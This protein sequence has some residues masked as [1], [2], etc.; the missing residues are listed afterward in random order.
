M[1]ASTNHPSRPHIVLLISDQHN[2]GLM[3]CAG[4]PWV[5]TPHLDQLAAEGC[6]FTQCYCNSPV[7][8]PSRMSMLTGQSPLHN[9][10]LTNR[11]ALASHIP[12]LAHA[13]AA[14]GY[15]TVLC[16]RMHFIG[17]DQRHGFAERLVGEFG[18]TDPAFRELDLG[19]FNHSTG[20]GRDTLRFNG[21]GQGPGMHY[22]REVVDA[23]CERIGTQDPTRPLFMVIGT[24]APHNPYVCDPERFK[25]YQACLPRPDMAEIVNKHARAHPA[26]RDWLAA[27]EML[28][29]DPVELHRARAA[30]YGMVEEMDRQIGR[31]IACV[32]THLGREN[33]Y[34]GYGSDHGDLVGKNG[35]FWKSCFLDEAVKV[36][37]IWRGPGIVPGR[38]CDELISLLDLA[39]TLTEWGRTPSLPAAEGLSLVP[40][41]RENPESLPE[42]RCIHSVLMDPRT[43]ASLMLRQGPYK[44]VQYARYPGIQWADLRENDLWEENTEPPPK[45]FDQRIPASWAPEAME[46]LGRL[47]D[48]NNQILRQAAERQ[49][50]PMI[51]PW[52]L[53]PAMF[54]LSGSG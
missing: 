21:P 13:L 39:P 50:M 45:F 17:P 32:D 47:N 24:H 41:M 36:P 12:T 19:V 26:L 23:A 27:R 16:G 20:Q 33:V 11:Q 46:A 15:D 54:F 51:E 34:L 7:C 49:E 10:V 25:A 1:C 42:D 4:D 31:A 43:G 29:P 28:N 14:A 30:Y 3:G 52:Q 48:Q 44:W 35:M 53:D 8:G 2:A 22:D 5:R 6:R 9:G 38:G 18:P 37:M 40:L